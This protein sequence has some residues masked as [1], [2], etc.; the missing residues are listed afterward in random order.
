LSPFTSRSFIPPATAPDFGIPLVDFT[1]E[2]LA[3]ADLVV[4]L[5][6]HPEFDHDVVCANARLLFDTKGAMRGCDTPGETL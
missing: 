4:L 3:A 1:P 5:V 2:E 6:D